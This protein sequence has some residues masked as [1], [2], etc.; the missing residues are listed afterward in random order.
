MPDL[1]AFQDAFSAA[2]RGDAQGLQAWLADDDAGLSVYRNTCAKGVVDALQANFPAVAAMVGEAW[3]RAAAREF[4]AAHPPSH[5]ALHA[6]GE[7]FA[8]WLEAFPPAAAL[9]YL[10][11]AARL[12]RLWLEVLFAADAEPL[13]ADALARL[14]ADAL[15]RTAARASPATRL[16]W[17]PDNSPSLWLATRWPPQTPAELE[18][19]PEPQG[20]VVGRRDDIVRA[21]LVGAAEFAFL[22]AGLQ[23]RPLAQAARAALEADP[24]ADLPAILA[25]ALEDGLF[26]ALETVA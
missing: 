13:T 7:A 16:A 17:A 15:E 23:R 19:L 18:F 21:R 14:D 20:V 26:T 5:P 2:L 8:G 24:R 12:D 9:P 3:F 10:P 25:A 1:A 4:S 11:S 22:S 6:Y